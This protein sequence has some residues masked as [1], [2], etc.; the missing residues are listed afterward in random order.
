MNTPWRRVFVIASLSTL[1]T[2][3]CD[4][5][6]PH[7]EATSIQ[8]SLAEAPYPWTKTST[9][10]DPDTVRFAVFAD[11][12]GGERDGVFDTAIQQLNLLRPELIVNVGDLIEGSAD[13]TEI[14]AQWDRLDASTGQARAPVFYVGGN[15][16]LLGEAMRGVWEQRIGPRYYHFRYR[17]VLFL[18][19]DTEDHPAQRLEE[20]AALRDEMYRVAAEQGWDAAGDT[21]YAN[22]PENE[23]GIISAAQADYM[24]DALAA[25]VDVNWTFVLSHKAPWAGDDMATWL[26]IEQALADRPYTVFQGHR[27]ALKHT[28]RFGRDYIRLATTGGVLLP[29]NGPAF[30]HLV[31]VTV[32]DTGADI[33]LLKMSGILDKTGEIPN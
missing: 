5:P 18:V 27:H 12:T 19:L 1:G 14:R 31:W 24:I 15:H 13:S 3:G 7:E 23:T 2:T 4:A 32:D 33:A 6:D 11:I 20:L 30:D 25:N 17:N 29:N 10:Y 16:D 9:D 21:E 8:H 28:E 22:L 26:Q